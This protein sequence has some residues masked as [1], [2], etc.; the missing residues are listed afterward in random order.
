MRIFTRIK[1]FF[2]TL[3]LY[4]SLRSKSHAG[5]TCITINFASG[6]IKQHYV[7]QQV[8]LRIRAGDEMIITT[9]DSTHGHDTLAVGFALKEQENEHVDLILQRKGSHMR[10]LRKEQGITLRS[11]A[12][13]LKCTA[14]WLSDL[15]RGRRNWTK[16]WLDK[17]QKELNKK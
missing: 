9:G 14:Q 13:R 10:R 17:Y 12:K 11:M 8:E 4:G 2:K 3:G 7:S 16:D 5:R 6:S 1:N 15:E